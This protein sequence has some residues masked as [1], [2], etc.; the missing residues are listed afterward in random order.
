MASVI[1]T[2]I[3]LV[4]PSRAQVVNA[5]LVG[6]VT[7][8]S[9]AAVPSA[10]LILTNV[11]TGLVIKTTSDDAG[12]Y[13]F[14]VVSPGSYKLSAEKQ[15]FKSTVI[16]GID[17]LVDQQARIDVRMEIGAVTT[18]VEV[19]G[20]APL[21]ESTTASIGTVIEAQQTVQLPLN[22]RRYGSLALLVPGTMPENGGSSDGVFGSPFSETTYAANGTR[23]SS[24][25]YLIDGMESW[26]LGRGGFS[27]QPPP[28][29]IEEFKIQTNIY[30]AAF[31]RQAGSTIN[32]VTKSGTNEFHGVVY[33]FLRND[34]LDA[35]NFFEADVAKYKRNQFGFAA[36]GPIIKQKTFWFV[37]YEGLRDIKGASALG[38][39]PT[40][41]MKSG[42][43]SSALT[44]NTLNLCGT[45]GPANL[46]FDSGQLFDPGTLDY[47]TCPAGSANAGQTIL[48]GTP[49]AGN[50]ITNINPV[51][52]KVL[53][54]GAF[55]EPN[56]DG[57]NNF[58]NTDPRTRNDDL[59]DARIDHVIGTNDRISGRYFLGNSN[60][61]SPVGGFTS[62]P[63]FREKYVFRGHNV[64]LS[65][66][67]NFGPSLLNEARFGFQRESSSVLCGECP[68]SEGFMASFGIDGLS[69]YG[70]EFEGFPLFGISNFSS[71]G[72]SPYRPSV[73]PDMVEKY[74]DNLTWVHGKHTVVVGA[75]IQL[76]QVLRMTVPRSVY[77]NI[78][79]DGRYSSLASEIPDVALVSGFADFLAGYPSSGD[80]SARFQ[81]NYFIGGGFWNF[82]AQD[83]FK[84]SPDL[85]VN[86]GVRYE[87]RRQP[88][89]KN[90]NL[91]SFVS[92]A[93]PFS[94]PGN[95]I[96]VTALN[97]SAN[98]ALC[99]DPA[100]S[101]L[102]S[103]DGR[104]LVASSSQRG[105]LGFTGRTQRTLIFPNRKGWAPRLGLSFRP[106]HSDKLIIRTGYGIFYDFLP[107]ENLYFTHNSP[108]SAPTSLYTPA[109]GAPPPTVG[110]V[111]T[112][113]ETMFGGAS[114]A[115]V[116]DQFLA[117]YA[118]P[119]YD[120]PYLQQWS[121]GISSQ[122]ARDWALELNYVGNKG[123]HQGNLH[124]LANQ[125]RP[126]LGD[127]QPRR[128]YPDFNVMLFTTTDANSNYHSLQTRLTKR[129]TSG[130]NMLI[131]YTW[132]KAINDG[133]GNEG[134]GGG[135]G[136]N[137]NPQDDN[138]RAIDRARSYMDARHRFVASYVWDL[139]VG[140]DKRFLNRPGWQ[141]QVVGGWQVSG[142]TTF[143][144]GFPMT[145][146]PDQ[147]YSNTGSSTPRPDRL[148]HGDGPKTLE[149]WFEPSC[150]TNEALQEA[151]ASGQPRF[152][153]SGR[154]ILNAPGSISW[155]LALLKNF[156]MGDRFGLQFRAE[157]YSLLNHLNPG[158]PDATIGSPNAGQIFYGKGER[159]L[160]FGLK[161]S[162]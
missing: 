138:N 65:W 143:Q 60:T 150:F 95:A 89:E 83:D 50:I 110:G 36:G 122:F 57:F 27:V 21:V 132:A 34:V 69:A 104:C 96:L 90:G 22:L 48:V 140:A 109:F 133:E 86:V 40:A 41:A 70:P 100:W 43:L 149:Q 14:P 155:D 134:F 74:Q 137:F 49:Y 11:A 33:E 73:Y 80:H 13:N 88:E 129:W 67:R 20:A 85:T 160:Q 98:D 79:S 63:S 135:N 136:G 76:W 15:G 147:D 19:V 23:T 148:C 45:G 1:W 144:S 26:N 59:L 152:G 42:D 54:S 91:L 46:D 101:F 47:F 115:P 38:T 105:Q 68:R 117:L 81:P 55:P 7:D 64:A 58:I 162:Y 3:A 128:P 158:Y 139:P 35:R 39:V 24:N 93:M 154:N 66:I 32:L 84:I 56:R 116:Q 31:G 120:N 112:T 123:T 25:S 108:L 103:S 6:T 78:A 5:R 75:D 119:R 9:N 131:S 151:L 87:Y 113:F 53:D 28:D 142:I 121:F 8:S 124:D 4:P 52:Q 156:A 102:Y 61:R 18:T 161:L 44:G 72:D 30:S 10:D 145:I 29:A 92:T 97:D 37:N 153:N 127:L 159:V 62:L 146:F 51:A 82:Y 17:L 126:G 99:T 94:G 141:N 130:L 106:T 77:G 157:A 114:I 118:S 16:T 12:D 111:P 71:V 125:P 2:T 107:T